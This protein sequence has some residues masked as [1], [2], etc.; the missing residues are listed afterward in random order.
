MKAMKVKQTK[1]PKDET[2]IV[3][4]ATPMK[5]MKVMKAGCKPKVLARFKEQ[6]TLNRTP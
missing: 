3:A 1:T 2:Q 4:G 5:A 6:L